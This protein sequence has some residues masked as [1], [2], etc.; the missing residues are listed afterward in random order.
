[1]TNGRF[2]KVEEKETDETKERFNEIDEATSDETTVSFVPQALLT[3][4]EGKS[5][6]LSRSFATASWKSLY[7]VAGPTSVML[8]SV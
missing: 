8:T 6:T 3:D 2:G 1:M 7:R 4:G 5:A